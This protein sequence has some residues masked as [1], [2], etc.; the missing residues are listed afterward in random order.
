MVA[1]FNELEQITNEE[2]G[3]DT[4][5]INLPAGASGTV[6]SRAEEIIAPVA[7]ALGM[8]IVTLY[9]ISPGRETVQSV[10][11]S[12]KNGLCGISHVK[13]AVIN[14]YLGD[15]DRYDWAQS[16]VRE[17]WLADGGLEFR[18]PVLMPEIRD[19]CRNLGGT[20]F[21]LVSGEAPGLTLVERSVVSRWLRQTQPIAET[22]L[23]LCDTEEDP[24]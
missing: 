16:S 4:I 11:A 6:D 10:E 9:A 15:G 19:K 12:V 5:I 3:P 22:A 7:E 17:Q 1:L 18:L 21:Q 14:D 2:H 23:G 8:E 20:L 24:A 13:I